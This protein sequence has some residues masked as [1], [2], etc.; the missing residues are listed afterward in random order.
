M[1]KKLAPHKHKLTLDSWRVFRILSEIVDGFE[2]MTRLGP[3]VTV[4]GSARATPDSKYYQMAV[5]LAEKIANRGFAIVTGGG[6]GIMEAANKGAKQ[7]EEGKS[8]GICVRLPTEPKPNDFI[9]PRSCLEFRY[10]F[11]RKIMFV[12][13][14]QAFVIFPGGVGSLDELFEA[15]TL[16]QTQKIKAIPIYLVGKDFWDK[17]LSWMRDVVLEEGF[18]SQEDLDRMIVTDDLDEITDGIVSFYEQ[19]QSFENF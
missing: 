18:I 7:A 3:A 14:A 15:L 11:V 19:T 1:E 9:D 6:P 17:M 8:C 4:F 2:T 5:D 10:F 16:L 12:R 13:Y